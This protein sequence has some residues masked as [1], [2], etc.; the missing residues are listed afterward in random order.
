MFNTESHVL[1][2]SA[3]LEIGSERVCE[4]THTKKRVKYP[5]SCDSKVSV[6][7]HCRVGVGTTVDTHCSSLW[8]NLIPALGLPLTPWPLHPRRMQV[9]PLMELVRDTS[10][11]A[12]LGW[13]RWKIMRLIKREWVRGKGKSYPWSREKDQLRILIVMWLVGWFFHI[14][15]T[16]RNSL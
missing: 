4:H 6:S 1:K 3:G 15:A 2:S 14:D 13:C 5:P 8:G 12:Q 16:R 9:I 7:D 10:Q 11:A